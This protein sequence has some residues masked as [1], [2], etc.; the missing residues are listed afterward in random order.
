MPLALEAHIALLRELVK[1]IMEETRPQRMILLGFSS[2][3]DVVLRLLAHPA[4]DEIRCNAAVTLGANLALET[5]WITRRLAQLYSYDEG[6]LLHDLKTI[7]TSAGAVHEWLNVHEYLVRVLRKFQ[8]DVEPLRVVASGFARPFEDEGRDVF[9]GWYR[10]V[11]SR[12]PILICVNEDDSIC[13][14]LVQDLRLRNLDSGIL[15]PRYLE[16]SLRL[17]PDADHFD[18]LALPRVERYLADAISRLDA[19]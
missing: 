8:H 17:E 18:L 10:A 13:R 16:D 14:A 12:I 15:G 9:P 11:T 3:G 2:G 4:S 5:C 19:E 7:A 6:T 1:A